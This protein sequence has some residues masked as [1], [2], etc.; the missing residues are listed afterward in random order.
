MLGTVSEQKNGKQTNLRAKRR[1]PMMNDKPDLHETLKHCPAG[2]HEALLD[3]QQTG[4]V[5]SLATFVRGA[6]IRHLD[7]EQTAALE[8][9]SP[10]AKL[11]DDV[12]IDSL[13]M[14]E[15]VIM[16]EECLDISIPTEDLMNLQTLGSLNEY[17]REKA[18]AVA[19]K[20][21]TTVS[22]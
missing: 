17:L 18:S 22:N 9:A 5:A 6:M 11:I 19:C 16:I 12:G 15:I 14:T 3:F 8:A 10:E 2:T 1:R 13:T 4:S 21:A 20:S 7:P